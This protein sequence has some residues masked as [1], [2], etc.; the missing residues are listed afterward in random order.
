M[1][2]GSTD[3]FVSDVQVLRC[4]A[5]ETITLAPND[6]CIA[7]TFARARIVILPLQLEL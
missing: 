1:R 6:N 3:A 2:G 4:E 5:E 7:A